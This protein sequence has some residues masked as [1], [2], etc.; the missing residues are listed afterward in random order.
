[1]TEP[2]YRN[3]KHYISEGWSREPKETFKA[4]ISLLKREGVERLPSILDVGCATGELLGYLT[5]VWSE[6]RRVGVDVTEDLLQEGRRLLPRVEFM[7]ASALALPQTL[8]AQFDLV[9]SIGCMSIFDEVEIERY[10]D[11]LLSATRPGGLFIVLSPL[12]EF[13]VDAIIHHRKR[14]ET[15]P[16]AWE[17]GWNI[18][19]QKT[20]DEILKGRGIQARFERFEI[21]FDLRPRADPIRTWTMRTEQRERQLTNGLK[22]LIDHYFIF[23]QNVR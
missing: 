21:P 12:N 17:K 11:N 13:G 4:L 18:F 7:K 1:M 19:S 22:L 6:G 2:A 23:G 9:T 15:G 8:H 14:G 16:G 3:H 5:S 10:W 20:I